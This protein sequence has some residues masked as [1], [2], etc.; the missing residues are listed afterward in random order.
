M[1]WVAGTIP[2]RSRHRFAAQPEIRRDPDVH[3]C[4]EPSHAERA[5]IRWAPLVDFNDP[6][7]VPFDA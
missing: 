7:D 2:R 1:V 4:F 5:A 3:V 6:P